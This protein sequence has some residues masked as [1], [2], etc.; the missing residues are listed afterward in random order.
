MLRAFFVLL[1][2][3][4]D[5]DTVSGL[6]HQALTVGLANSCVLSLVGF[7]LA[8]RRVWHTGKCADNVHVAALPHGSSSAYPMAKEG[9]QAR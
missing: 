1:T 7:L 9:R 5:Y 3:I 8:L 6:G 2:L 4:T